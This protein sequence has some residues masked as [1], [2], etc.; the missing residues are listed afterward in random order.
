MDAAIS[1]K[2]LRALVEGAQQASTKLWP[3]DG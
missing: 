1:F 2:K 3:F